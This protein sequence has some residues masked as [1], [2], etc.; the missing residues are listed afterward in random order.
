MNRYLKITIFCFALTLFC[1]SLAAASFTVLE[2]TPD[3][4]RVRF[5]LPQWHL[6]E[7]EK[8]GQQWQQI[9]CDY[10]SILSQEGFPL[11]RQYSDAIGIPVDGDINIEVIS[12]ATSSYPN[13]NIKPAEKA[14]ASE[15]DISYE[16]YQDRAAYQNSELY[17]GT[18][19]EKGESAYVGD[20]HM[21][22]LQIFPFRYNAKAK[23]LWVTEE[24]EIIV[25]IN[26]DKSPNRNW[27]ETS[28]YID[29]AGDSFFLNNQTSKVWRLSKTMSF[30]SQIPKSSNQLVNEVQL[31]V[32]REGIYKITYEYLTA[33]M[34][35][36][37]DSLGIEY[38]WDTRSVDPR[39]L[40]LSDEFGPVAVFFS[41]E[42]DGSFDPEDYFEF[43]GER[44]YG[45]ISYADDYTAENVYALSLTDGLGAR[46]AVENGGLVVSVASNY[47]VP[48]AYESTI[49]LEQQIIPEKLGRS[50]SLNTSFYREDLWFWEKITAPNLEIIPFELQYPKDT[51][52]RTFSTK[53]ALYGLT[54][55]D[56]L[57]FGQYDHKATIRLNQSLI[58]TKS[59][60][61]QTE[62]IFQNSSPIP[63]S[64]LHHG[65][66][67]YYISMN[68]DTPME[69]REQILLD[70]IDLTYWR[71]YKTSEDF[72]KFTKPS[73]RPFGLY[74][75]QIEGFS[76]DKVSVYKIG[77]SIMNNLQVESFTLS[78]EQPWTVTFQD[79]VVSNDVNYYAVTEAGKKQPKNFVVNIPS[80]LRSAQN[81]ADCVVIT[82]SQ[83]TASDGTLLYKQIWENAGYQV[84]VVDIQDIYDEFNFGIRSAEA[85]KEFLT[86]AY[87]NWS[88]PQLKSVVLLGD[89]TTDERDHS[90]SRKY[91]IVPVKKLWTYQHG[92]TACDNWYAC[93]VG[94][95]PIPD[96]SISRINIWQSDQI[97]TAAQKSQTYFNEP[98]FNDLWH[99]HLILSTG[100]KQSDGNDIF[101]QQSEQIRRTQI[102]NSIRA[103]R[104]YTNT[105]SVSPEFYGVTSTLMSKINDGAIYLQFMGHGGGRIWADYNLFNF[106][107]VSSLNNENYPYVV[108]LACYCGAFDTDGAASIS[109]ALILAPDKGAIAAF[110]FSGLGYL[111][112]D[113]DMGLAINECLFKYDFDSLGEAMN[114]AK[115]KFY[116]NTG[117]LA[118]QGALT[119]GGALLGDPNVKIIKPQ[120]KII[121]FTDKD[122]YAYNDTLRVSAAFQA[123]T[124]AAR[125]FVMKTTE[126]AINPPNEFPVIQGSYNYSFALNGE[127]DDQYLRRVHVSGY[128][129][130]GEYYGIKEIAIGS[131]LLSHAAT[132][133]VSPSW[134]D[135]I[136]FQA[137]VSS[138]QNNIGN[139]E[140]RIRLDSLDVNPDW[141]AIPMVRTEADT[142]LYQTAYGLAAQP[143]GKE[144]VYKYRATLANNQTQESVLNTIV[145][146]GPELLIEDMQIS[147][148][149][150]ALSVS[151]KTKNIGNSASGLT[152]ITL[153][154]FQQ[155]LPSVLIYNDD[156][157][158]L[159]INESRVVTMPIDTLFTDTVLLQASV[160]IPNLFPEWSPY[161]SNNSYSL[162]LDM[163]YHLLDSGGGAINSLDGNLE[164]EIPT[165]LIM[166]GHTAVFY[167]NTL[168]EVTANEQPD[169]TPLVLQ[170]GAT[171]IPYEIGTIDPELVDSSGFFVNGKKVK[172]T[173][174]YSSSDEQTQTNE[175]DNNYIIYRWQPDY[176]KWIFQ[177]G[178][179][180]LAQDKVVF[181]VNRQGIYT[182]MMNKDRKRPSIDVNVQDQEFTVGGYISGKGTISMLLSDA[183]GIDVFDNTI[184]LFLQGEEIPQD[185]WVKTVNKDDINR[186][187]IKYQLNLQKGDYTIVVDCKDLNGNFA[188]RDIQ[189]VVNDQFDVINLANY[190]NPVIGKTEDPKNAGRTRF[191]YVLTDD[192]D[193]VN[194]KI[195]TVSGRLIRTFSN[196]PTGVGYH[197]Y[198]RTV[199]A[200]DCKDEQGFYLANGVYFYRIMAKKGNKK[201]EKIQKMAILK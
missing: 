41:G 127:S 6:Q 88:E 32:D 153:T 63:N 59:W 137:R 186:I 101:S 91:N 167:I 171:S 85:I 184:K 27:Q 104:V 9:N 185:Q 25:R 60:R 198:P 8:N 115:A 176:K 40:Q 144:F 48:D 10:G 165:N 166:S 199:Y 173:F 105:Q 99:G 96:I 195:Y 83:F 50:W 118:A 98:N 92:A 30:T 51:T 128:S 93:I 193:E 150:N 143:T 19:V 1:S 70:Y 103:S 34:E 64:Y 4:L 194:I 43:Y 180:S 15:F 35:L 154:A 107:N 158:P 157:Q 190:P 119:H 42:S 79:S 149:D 39:Y 182:L 168:E 28:N 200:W 181:E 20:R 188:T 82:A 197:E 102:P 146:A 187:P 117:S 156:F 3:Y 147:N 67:Y 109:E 77:S 169:I 29:D 54:Y 130:Q 36:M 53:V 80:T 121:V 47:I 89:G 16:F 7:F 2:E 56:N 178:N 69:D 129:N 179:I 106:N 189:F 52:I 87:N 136:Y 183:N 5:T 123:N 116:V 126:I 160:N 21:I 152:T 81:A 172:L 68:G 196:L 46:M 73:N 174:H 161:T 159:G 148:H 37:A 175:G 17:P 75:F 155:G 151:V 86:F 164:C 140:C 13:I 201:I 100:G 125:T 110:G 12:Q 45:E 78:G 145:V 113:L 18:L 72:I 112:N 94:T 33:K 108:S 66:N 38:N 192:A 162:T 65:T 122:S 44:H 71:E 124:N 134:Q 132:I 95:D 191:T 133:P 141:I 177:G 84:D 26:G 11:L 57:P 62:Q 24:A 120:K 135:S 22:P 163:N 23:E 31:I 74:Q 170:S 61:D 114:V 55:M 14:E 90:S 131:G 97:L 58:D 139:V 49:H 142:T 111:Y 138:I 76:N